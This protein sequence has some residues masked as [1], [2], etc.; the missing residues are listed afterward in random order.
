MY[1]ELGCRIQYLKSWNPSESD[2]LPNPSEYGIHLDD[3][4]NPEPKIVPNRP[5]SPKSS[6]T[7]VTMDSSPEWTPPGIRQNPS[8]SDTPP[9][10]SESR[11]VN[12]DTEA[13]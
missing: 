2:C 3:H 7:L 5:K 10:P 12:P 11:T 4:F 1:T 9:N 8:E 13:P 6:K